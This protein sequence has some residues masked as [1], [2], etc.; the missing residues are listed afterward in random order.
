[1]SVLTLLTFAQGLKDFDDGVDEDDGDISI[2]RTTII[3]S[4]ILKT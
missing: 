2:S 4:T 1:M 3:V